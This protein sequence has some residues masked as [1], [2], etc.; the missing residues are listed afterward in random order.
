MATLAGAP[1]FRSCLENSSAPHAPSRNAQIGVGVLGSKTGLLETKGSCPRDEQSRPRE[2][3]CDGKLAA[4]GADQTAKQPLPKTRSL[5]SQ[6]LEQRVVWRGEHVEVEPP[7]CLHLSRNRP[8]IYPRDQLV[9]GLTAATITPSMLS[10]V[11][12]TAKPSFEGSST[13]E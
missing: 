12:E 3:F 11:G 7:A 8:S 4:R 2:R 1:H 9:V 6:S 13:E 5:V 10:S